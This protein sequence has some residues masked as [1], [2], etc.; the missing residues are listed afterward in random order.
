MM[1]HPNNSDSSARPNH[2][3]TIGYMTNAI[4]GGGGKGGYHFSLWKG[5]QET[6]RAHDVN[7]V[8][9]I[10]GSFRI[11]PL[12]EY[13]FQRN[14]VFDLI[15]SDHIDGLI[16]SSAI[17]GATIGLKELG[18]YISHFSQHP[19]V[20]IGA[21]LENSTG[22]FVDNHSGAKEI[23]DH[24]IETHGYRRIAYIQGPQENV[25]AAVRYQAYLDSLEEHGIP[26]DPKLVFPGDFIRSGGEGAVSRLLDEA[27]INCEAIVAANDNMAMGAI[28]VLRGRGVTVPDQMAVVGFDDIPDAIMSF[29]TLT[30][31]HQPIYEI[32]KKAVEL[33]IEGLG[34]REL[35]QRETLLTRIKVRN[36]CGCNMQMA[37]SLTPETARGSEIHAIPTPDR[38]M[39][40][41][42]MVDALGCSAAQR[43][44]AE[45]RAG[46]LLDAVS[47]LEK[48]VSGADKKQDD[49]AQIMNAIIEKGPLL[50]WHRAISILTRSLGPAKDAPGRSGIAQL[51]SEIAWF[52]QSNVRLQEHY[53][54]EKQSELF[55]VISQAL[56]TTFNLPGLLETIWRLL[57]W[58][59]IEGCWL[60]LYDQ[61]VAPSQVTR[62]RVAYN[63]AGKIDLPEEG[64]LYPERWG[65]TEDMVNTRQS[66]EVIVNSLYF[67]ETKFGYVIFEM[68]EPDQKMLDMIA[69]Q[70][71]TALQGT[72]VVNDLKRMET[73]FRRQANTDPLTGIYNRRML[74]ALGE[75]AFELARQHKLPLSVAMIDVDHFKTVND[76]FGH[77]VGDQVLFALSAFIKSQTRGLDIFGRFGGEEFVI[78]LPETA[79]EGAVIFVERVRKSIEEHAIGVGESSIKL[80]VSIGMATL[81][82]GQDQ[83]IDNLI[84]KA[85]KA[86]YLAKQAGRN[87]VAIF[88]DN[89]PGN[90]ERNG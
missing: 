46:Q 55:R 10:G 27:K 23:V 90:V 9:F 45:E 60:F 17:L 39:L 13:E 76:R 66:F 30:T 1:S 43:Q 20:S 70:I 14:N 32:G 58:L 52:S 26:F 49:L 24:L 54:D 47:N 84:D 53:Q 72:K 69:S 35:P 36:S 79:P 85:D 40:I 56:I 63:R 2:R 25:E 65:L 50:P 82:H 11:S 18:R 15:S 4:Y 81:I 59:G 37:P 21:Q 3:Y 89:N 87:Q 16:V 71:S 42:Q 67:G 64:R 78:I 68:D 5:I 73:E 7:V 77:G 80:T 33:L 88:D 19:I 12:Y 83:R 75:P 86:L 41:R 8:C 48:A 28:S 22:L 6:A 62:L 57:P 61:P 74:Y 34:G 38:E 29:P 44:Q 51:S 31:V